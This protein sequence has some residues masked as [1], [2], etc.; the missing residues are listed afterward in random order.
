MAIVQSTSVIDGQEITIYVE[1][2]EAPILKGRFDEDQTRGELITK[3]VETAYDV[4]GEGMVLVRNC[5]RK[6]VEGVK[7]M[8]ET[9]RPEEFELKLAIKFDSEVGA[10]IAKASSG[11]QLEVTMRWKPRG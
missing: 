7:K 5:A 2:D 10:V 1:V 11:A 4:F 3:V 9:F 6:A 8:D